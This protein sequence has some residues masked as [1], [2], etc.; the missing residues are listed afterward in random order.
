MAQ[1]SDNGF[2]PKMTRHT[3]SIAEAARLISVP[4]TTL[5]GWTQPRSDA[6]GEWGPLIE[7][8]PGQR[9]LSFV[10][11]AEAFVLSA[12]RAAGVSPQ[13][14]R[15]AV[16]NLR[17]E[18]GVEYALASRR[19]F[20]DGA[21][22]LYA[23]GGDSRIREAVGRLVAVRD[24]Q[25]AFL[26]VVAGYLRRLIYDRDRVSKIRLETPGAVIIPG[27]G[28]GRPVFETASCLV[29][30]V[31]YHYDG[32]DTVEQLVED[33]RVPAEHIQAVIEQRPAW[34]EMSD[35]AKIRKAA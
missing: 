24:G 13:I 20:T 8:V 18:I 34:A 10:S 16:E 23:Y 3:Y 7:R 26:P 2:H 29:E 22:L 27:V 32:G 9:A 6:R 33:F 21:E 15:P 1:P 30:V 12:A 25:S 5:H 11:L 4:R 14:I 35:R 17:E 19:M 31:L 28:S